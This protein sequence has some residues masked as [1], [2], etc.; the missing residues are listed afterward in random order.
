MA[1]PTQTCIAFVTGAT[2]LVGSHLVERLVKEGL[3]PRCLVRTS[4]DTSLLKALGVDFAIGDVTDPPEKLRQAIGDCRTVFH[5]AAMVDDWAPRETMVR[6]NV[7]GTRNLLEACAGLAAL[8][9][10]V[11]VGSMVVLGMGPQ[12][13]LDETA[14]MVHTGDN[15]N[16]T[17][18]LAE[19]LALGYARGK[20]VPV[21]VCRPPYIYGERD[22][23]FFPRLFEPL[24]SG[25]FKFIG[26][27]NQPLTLICV[28]NLVEALLR[29]SQVADAVGEVFLV[30]DGES[31]S[32][33][34]LV[35]MV[36]RE[37]G[38]RMP[39]RHVPLWF[40]KPALPF[41]EWFAKVRGQPPILNR[42]KMKFMATPMTFNISKARRVLG[43]APLEPVRTSL[44]K[45][46]RW[47]REHHPEM[48][49]K[50]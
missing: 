19:E 37:M 21:V 41:V 39:R 23:Q 1:Q 47:Y 46:I 4:S 14:P 25:R 22:K 40:A 48:A 42:F 50:A 28:H 20:N 12:N 17:K 34:E 9:K 10:F 36:C 49:A 29:A 24:R 35:E 27:G 3:R 45:T 8:E 26:D 7:D 18:I 15:Y 43:Y 33:R 31:I 5:V 11:L 44:Q 2:G 38:Y 30:T 32:R 16:Y 6:V 13:N